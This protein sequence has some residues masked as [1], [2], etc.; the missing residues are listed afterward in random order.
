MHAT[1][2]SLVGKGPCA[3]SST[4]I[5]WWQDLAFQPQVK[6]KSMARSLSRKADSVAADDSSSETEF[7]AWC[8][9]LCGPSVDHRRC[10]CM[11]SKYSL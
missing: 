7:V 9:C 3:I 10:I 11:H 4:K 1:S 8:M 5:P 6:F 2:P